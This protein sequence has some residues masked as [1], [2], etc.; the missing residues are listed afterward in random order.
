MKKLPIRTLVSVAVLMT[1]SACSSTG[2]HDASADALRQIEAKQAA[3]EVREQS[4]A[5]REKALKTT[6]ISHSEIASGSLNG[7]L[8]PPGAKAGQCFT[9]VWMEP[10]Y[11]TTTER[12]LISQASERIEVIPAKYETSKK[13]VII[14]EASSKLVS[15]PATYKTVSEKIM[16][17]PARKVTETVPAVYATET[18]RVID[19]PAHTIWKKGT[20]P[21]QR[22]DSSTGEIMCLV[23][24]P[25][26]Y[27]T[28][29]K[30]VVKTPA[31]T[32]TRTI[33]AEYQTVTK[34]VV[35]T[36]AYTKTVEIP[37]MYGV[38]DVTKEIS[39][40]Q[41][42]RIPVP[43]K[44]TNVSHSELSRDG[45]MQWREIMCE[46][47]A[48]PAKISQIQRALTATGYNAGTPDGQYGPA[49]IRAVTAF[50]RAKGLPA[51]GNLSMDTIEALDLQ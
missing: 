33:A 29:N 10:Q 17:K 13:R 51:D 11:T 2:G 39:P 34:R 19:K 28:I 18:E 8:L 7:Q 25:A 22:I 27:K 24:V 42:R 46:T 47:N 16:V 43:A 35:D 12:K 37:A 6:K 44:F 3:L 45:E 14:Q 1:I 4:L 49:T 31:T 9:R 21:I 41:E 15:V 40:A 38:V 26:T 30:R 23:E 50:Q 36:K 32:R 48:T 5:D 20:G